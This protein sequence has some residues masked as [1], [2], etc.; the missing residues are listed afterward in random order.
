MQQVSFTT[1][2][3]FDHVQRA[4]DTLRSM[5]FALD[6]LNVEKAGTDL[7]RVEIRYRPQGGLSPQTFVERLAL[8]DGLQ[9]VDSGWGSRQPLSA[10]G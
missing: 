1:F 5:G 9:I 8:R 6:A 7:F 3:P 2:S 4:L 10:C